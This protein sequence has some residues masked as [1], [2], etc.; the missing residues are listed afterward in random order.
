M[1]PEEKITKQIVV[2]QSATPEELKELM[3]KRAEEVAAAYLKDHPEEAT[4][5]STGPVPF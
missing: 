2:D 3:E 4:P 5:P 1:E